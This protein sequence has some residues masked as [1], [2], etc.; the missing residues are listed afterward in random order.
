MSSQSVQSI[1][2]SIAY[3][4]SWINP[5]PPC[6]SFAGGDVFYPSDPL[7]W[8]ITVGDYTA[9]NGLYHAW[10]IVGGTETR[11][12]MDGSLSTF[13]LFGNP[14][15]PG[16]TW[17][18]MAMDAA[19]DVTTQSGFFNLYWSFTAPGQTPIGPHGRLDGRF[20]DVRPVPEPSALLLAALGA[21]LFGARHA[22]LIRRRHRS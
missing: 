4:T 20:T 8:S 11:V 15:V 7:W 10:S 6:C 18:P 17:S 14:P 16:S 19:A 21:T 3:D 2:W 9:V 5:G 1:L 13:G 22:R 12:Q